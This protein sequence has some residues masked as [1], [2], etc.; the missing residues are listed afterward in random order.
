MPRAG[1]FHGARR[2]VV[3]GF[4]DVW[5]WSGQVKSPDTTN[6]GFSRKV[7]RRFLKCASPALSWRVT[8]YQ[9]SGVR[10]FHSHNLYKEGLIPS[11][12]FNISTPSRTLCAESADPMLLAFRHRVHSRTTNRLCY[13][14][15]CGDTFVPNHSVLPAIS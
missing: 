1:N 5:Q 13:F 14:S 8:R 15:R 6:S 3:D 7:A 11:V 2:M 9:T 10:T 4:G 12:S